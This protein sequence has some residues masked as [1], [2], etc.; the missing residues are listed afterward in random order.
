[1]FQ[2]TKIWSLLPFKSQLFCLLFESGPVE[3]CCLALVA[4]AMANDWK[5]LGRF[6]D[7]PE[8]TINNIETENKSQDERSYQVLIS[9]SRSKASKATA[10]SLMKAVQDVGNVDAMERFDRHLGERHVEGTA[11]SE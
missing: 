6:L 2:L 11:T 9:W 10:H 3:A 5:F 4:K 7:V 8:T 1:M